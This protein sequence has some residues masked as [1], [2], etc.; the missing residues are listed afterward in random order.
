MKTRYVD[1][2]S[3]EDRLFIL[4]KSTEYFNEPFTGIPRSF[5]PGLEG[6]TNLTAIST[7]MDDPNLIKE[8]SHIFGVPEGIESIGEVS[9]GEFEIQ[10]ARAKLMLG[11]GRP[12]ISPSVYSSLCQGTPVVIPY[13]QGVAVP[14]GWKLFDGQYSQHGP[15]AAIGAPYVYSYDY[16][17]MT[18]LVEKVNAAASHPIER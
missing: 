10:L 2:E 3:R 6:Q 14:H 1:P 18:D 9:K 13:F 4:A 8:G 12:Y 5:W 15:A 16:Q 7:A 11:I 17:N